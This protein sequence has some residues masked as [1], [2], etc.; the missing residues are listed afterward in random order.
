MAN[1]K[2]SKTVLAASFSRPSCKVQSEPGTKVG[3]PEA[4]FL[5]PRR[6][7]MVLDLM[8]APLVTAILNE[9]A[10]NQTTKKAGATLIIAFSSNAPVPRTTGSLF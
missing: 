1:M 4:N 5:H 10:L 6:Q 7:R 2:R 8:K 3:N 9:T